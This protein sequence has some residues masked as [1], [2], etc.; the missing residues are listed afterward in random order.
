MEQRQ[1]QRAGM[2]TINFERINVSY[3]LLFCKSDMIL[4]SALLF[5]KTKQTNWFFLSVYMYY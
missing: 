5:K 3:Y 2:P 1:A 4:T